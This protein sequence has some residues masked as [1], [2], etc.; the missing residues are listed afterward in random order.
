[1]YQTSG[2]ALCAFA[3]AALVGAASGDQVDGNL[4]NP[5]PEPANSL[6]CSHL[7]AGVGFLR[8]RRQQHLLIRWRPSI[9]VRSLA[10]KYVK[11]RKGVSWTPPSYH[12]D[13]AREKS[14]KIDQIS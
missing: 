7:G 11:A 3:V 1:M 2:L 9:S 8:R 13:I 10:S 4:S 5:F 14:R 12:P 6:C